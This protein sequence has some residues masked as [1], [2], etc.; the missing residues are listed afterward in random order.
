MPTPVPRDR[1]IQL[2]VLDIDG[3]I[4]G[5]S[6]Q[7][8]EP[9]KQAVQA[10]QAQG[11]Q[12]AI[13]TGRMYQSAL[14]FHRDIGSTLPLISYQGALIKDPQT[15]EVHGHWPVQRDMALRLLDDLEQPEFR[16]LLSVHCYIHDQLHVRELTEETVNY[17]ERSAVEPFVV[18]DLRQSLH[19]EPTKILAMSEDTNLINYLYQTLCQRYDPSELYLTRS[20]NTF[21]EA[22]HPTANKGTAVQYLAEEVLGL[23]AAQ[24]MAIGDNYNDVEML[25]YAG[26]GV[27]MG[28]APEPVKAIAQW[29]AP[30]VNAD[31]VAVAIQQFLLD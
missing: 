31:G 20:V 22:A 14:R 9:V 21:V 29:V 8:R 2:L 15:E 28:D 7:I 30:D 4:A 6:N 19:T 17:A 3:T 24:V 16:D 10:A 27:A 12:V 5:R 26:L 11:I 1:D 23:A 25:E 13:A 18:G